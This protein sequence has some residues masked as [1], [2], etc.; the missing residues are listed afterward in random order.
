MKGEDDGVKRGRESSFW[1]F[2]NKYE[3]GRFKEGGQDSI[4]IR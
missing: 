4:L 2:L 1:N 3:Q